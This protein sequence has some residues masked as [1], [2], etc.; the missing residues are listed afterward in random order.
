MLKVGVIYVT[1]GQKIK[2]IRKNAGLTQ[3]ELAQKMGLSFQ[4]IAQ[5]END[6]RK[7]KIETLKKIADALEC[8]IDT[9]TT[10]DFDEEIPSPALVSQK[11]HE[12]RMAAGLTQQELAEKVGLDGATIGKYERG[13]LKPKAETVK[14]ITDALGI[15]LMDLY[16]ASS[17]ETLPLAKERHQKEILRE[18]ALPAVLS[19]LKAVYGSCDYTAIYKLINGQH[20]FESYYALDKKSGM[21]E[22]DVLEL[23]N[24][25]KITDIIVATLLAATDSFT[26]NERD[27]QI[28][29]GE[30]L[31]SNG[32]W[33]A[34]N[35]EFLESIEEMYKNKRFDREFSIEELH[36]VPE[37]EED[38]EDTPPTEKE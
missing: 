26:R 6:L 14:K 27:V 13:I 5:W 28:D 38:E 22:R 30:R 23:Y 7:P 11:I 10:D 20:L 17:P 15:N 35:E 29:I 31:K 36:L 33:N 9:F 25:G 18:R 16:I 12:C 37:W 2:A 19:L 1:I 34:Q 24:I 21:V 3:K 8:P 32:K 4:S